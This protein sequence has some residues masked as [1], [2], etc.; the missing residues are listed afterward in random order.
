MAIDDIFNS[1]I[2][3]SC[4]LCTSTTLC[5]RCE[6][7]TL[8]ANGLP[9]ELAPQISGLSKIWR[10]NGGFECSDLYKKIIELI[11]LQRK[12]KNK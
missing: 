4:G 1:I 3:A 2:C 12:T 11:N 9:E 5:S 6:I 7:S 8:K 10:G